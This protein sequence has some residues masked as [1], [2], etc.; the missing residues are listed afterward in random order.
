MQILLSSDLTSVVHRSSE[1]RPPR[2]YLVSYHEKKTHKY[3][4]IYVCV[5]CV[6]VCYFTSKYVYSYR[7]KNMHGF[8]CIYIWK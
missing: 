5:L 4:Y 6:Y 3:I 2:F 7:H 1:L 8:L